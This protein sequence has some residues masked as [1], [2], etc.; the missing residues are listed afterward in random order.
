MDISFDIDT[1]ISSLEINAINTTNRTNKTPYKNT[2]S[3]SMTR[4]QW[5]SLT[6]DEKSIWDSFPP[7]TKAPI[8]RFRKPQPPST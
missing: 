3:P 2:F 7:Q 8:L 6:A 4:D 5:N 1:A